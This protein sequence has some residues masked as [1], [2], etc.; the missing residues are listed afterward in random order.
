[1]D[2]FF[3]ICFKGQALRFYERRFSYATR[4]LQATVFWTRRKETVR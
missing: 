4:W 2:K 1:M 3:G